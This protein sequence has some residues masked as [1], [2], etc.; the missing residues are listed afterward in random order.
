MQRCFKVYADRCTFCEHK[1]ILK[2]AWV[3]VVL[4][5]CEG[6]GTNLLMEIGEEGTV[7]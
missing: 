4:D 6:P 1:A 5:Y 7:S 2:E 3:F